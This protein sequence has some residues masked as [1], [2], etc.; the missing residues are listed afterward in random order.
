MSRNNALKVYLEKEWEGF[1]LGG[2]SV[3]LLFSKIESWKKE[4]AGRGSH[5]RFVATI[6]TTSGRTYY[7]DW[8]DFVFFM[9][10]NGVQLK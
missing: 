3:S 5:S 1:A 8:V 9:K 6:N 2:D 7:C 4:S 10:K